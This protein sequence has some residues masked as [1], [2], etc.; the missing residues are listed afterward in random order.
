MIERLERLH[1]EYE[2]FYRVYQ[3][4]GPLEGEYMG[5]RNTFTDENEMKANVREAVAL[6]ED[7]QT[8]R[9]VYPGDMIPEI[10]VREREVFASPWISRKV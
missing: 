3:T 1:T 9:E 6:Q 2:V 4:G 10:T 8:F 7:F 5:V